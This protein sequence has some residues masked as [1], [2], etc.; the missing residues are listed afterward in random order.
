MISA[1]SLPW[2]AAIASTVLGTL[3]IAGADVDARS[4]L[5]PDLIT[6]GALFC[7]ILAAPLLDTTDPW[8]A[9]VQAIARAGCV[10]GA[11]ALFRGGYGW[12]RKTEG[13]GLGDVKLAAA[14]GT[15][16]P[17]EAIPLC[18]G[19]ATGGALLTGMGARLR[20]QAVTRP[21][22]GPF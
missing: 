21:P 16:L 3:M 13:L 10:A 11:L 4:F 8:A 17:L 5:L 12:I 18:F 9:A 20:G 7:G 2:P 14:I 1:L 15:W 22:R 6:F 19:L